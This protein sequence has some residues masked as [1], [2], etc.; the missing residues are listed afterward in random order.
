MLSNKQKRANYDA[1]GHSQSTTGGGNYGYQGGPEFTASH[2]EQIFRQFFGQGFTGGF[3]FDNYEQPSSARTSVH[4]VYFCMLA[5]LV[6]LLSHH[7]VSLNLS[8][9]EAIEGCSRELSFRVQGVCE[10]CSGTKS[11]PGAKRTKC[12]YCRGSGEVRESSSTY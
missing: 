1:Y 2:A 7:K 9:A 6:Y 3:D 10:R 12:P 4:Q 11:E 5:A 8:F